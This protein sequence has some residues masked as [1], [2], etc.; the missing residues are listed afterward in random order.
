[1]GS[2]EALCDQAP[3]ELGDRVW[4]DTNGNG[5]Q[6][7]GEATLNGVTVELWADTNNDGLVRPRVG[8][9]TTNSNGLYYFGGASGTNMLN[10]LAQAQ[11]LS[12]CA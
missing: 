6:D 2:V 9:T 1:M 11:Q 12:L 4:Q 7:P 3:L 5:L 8:A 10:G